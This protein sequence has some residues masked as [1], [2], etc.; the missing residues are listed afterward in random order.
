MPD[1][2]DIFRFVARNDQR[3]PVPPDTLRGPAGNAD[4]LTESI[5][6]QAGSSPGPIKMQAVEQPRTPTLRQT[7]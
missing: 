2:E 7:V 4:A 3:R 5:E 1:S 6:P